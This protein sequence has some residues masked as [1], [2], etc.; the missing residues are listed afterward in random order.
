MKLNKRGQGLA[1]YGLI[2]V[3]VGL[4]CY[5]SLFTTA[6]TT[7]GFYVRLASDVQSVNDGTF[8]LP[9]GGRDLPSMGGGGDVF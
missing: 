5:L 2:A 1:E 6:D 9:N 4:V 3:L 7:I 8:T